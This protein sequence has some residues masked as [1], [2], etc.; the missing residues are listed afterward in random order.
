MKV[1]F[2]TILLIAAFQNIYGQ[3]SIPVQRRYVVDKP[4]TI[5]DSFYHRIPNAI[6]ISLD[7]GFDDSLYVTV[8]DLPVL[9]GYFKTN[10]SIGYA[11]GFGIH[12]KDS[13][14]IKKLKIMFVK[15]NLYILEQVNL[16]YKSL[17]IGKTNPWVL[18]YNNRFPIQE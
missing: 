3:D 16:R 14:E 11:A 5:A 1:L 8:N 7:D 2:C 6:F 13:S 17:R 15:T 9:S 10:E 18:F 12:F 4:V